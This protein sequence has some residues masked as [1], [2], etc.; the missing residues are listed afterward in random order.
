MGPIDAVMSRALVDVAM[1]RAHADLV[2]KNGRWVCVQS[3]E[4][5]TGADIAIKGERIA[6]VGESADHTIGK[7]TNVIDAKN[8]FLVPGLLDGHMH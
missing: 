1:G 7:Q 4:I 3:G 6:Y 8:S 5:I 2:I